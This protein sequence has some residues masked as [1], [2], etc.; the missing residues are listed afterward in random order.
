MKKAYL[1]LE[2]G[3]TLEGESF[4]A[5]TISAGEVVFNTG[6]T[7]YPE[8]LTDPSYRGQ[9]LTLTYPLIGN[10]GVPGDCK[11]SQGIKKYFESNHVHVKGLVV[12][13]YC[14]DPSHWHSRKT[15]HEWLKKN[16][17]PGIS[18]IDTRALTQ[19][20]R[21]KG[22][23]LG[24]IS[25][26]PKDKTE[27]YNPDKDNLVAQVSTKRVRTYKAGSKTVV[28]I[29]CGA[30]NNI[31]RSLL[32]RNITVIKVPW[33]YD[34]FDKNI[35][36]D[37]IFLSNGPGDPMTITKTHAIVK[38]CLKSNLPV[39]GICLGN[40]VM[41]IAAGAKT[42]KLPYGHRAQNQPC[43]NKETGTC[44]I[45]SQNHGFAVEEKSLPKEFKPW[46]VNVNDK[47]IEGIKHVSKPIMA[48]QFHPEATPGPT[49]T[50]YLFDE[51]VAQ[52]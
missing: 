17:I 6:M 3:T 34:F 41:A 2:D 47:T 29:D 19:K 11:D 15:L 7:G 24:K 28:L 44:F 13:E 16:D 26:S 33:D 49:D 48:V 37:G 51:F 10:Y 43:M 39:F 25:S 21:E 1:L 9:I 8:S 45:T 36:A 46:F 30:K 40:Q 38:K 27:F 12:S 20:L 52:L 42:Y 18:G 5:S 31:I 4:G 23:M 50:S 14:T 22:T 32:Q 35:Q